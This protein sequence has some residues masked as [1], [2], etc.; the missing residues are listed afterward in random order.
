MNENINKEIG[1]IKVEIPELKITI[2]EVTVSHRCPI[3]CTEGS[4]DR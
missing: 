2:T 3:S 4:L 1:I